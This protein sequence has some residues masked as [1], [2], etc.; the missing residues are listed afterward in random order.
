MANFIPLYQPSQLT[1]KQRK[2]MEWEKAA[3]M[4]ARARVQ[5]SVKPNS[6]LAAWLS[7]QPVPF[8]APFLE[9]VKRI[10][11]E[12]STVE[13]ARLLMQL[14][15]R[16]QLQGESF[17]Q[18]L[19]AFNSMLSDLERLGQ[20]IVPQEWMDTFV[21]NISMTP[22]QRAQVAT[23]R[24]SNPQALNEPGAIVA[25]LNAIQF[26]I[27]A[28]LA[29]RSTGGGGDKGGG[30]GAVHHADQH[31]CMQSLGSDST[32][33]KKKGVCKICKQPGHWASDCPKAKTAADGGSE[34]KGKCNAGQAHGS[35]SAAFC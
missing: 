26:Q 6:E 13:R 10:Y 35:W 32:E 29:L 33:K 14:R 22:A 16:R 25:W 34:A 23:V 27:D 18:F 31:R 21:A 4:W 7:N 3:A 17:E 8:L 2:S 9:H 20:P 19:T 24:L 5:E 15:S 12:G 28:Q 11:A 1:P 30:S